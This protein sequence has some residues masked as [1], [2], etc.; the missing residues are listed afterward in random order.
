MWIISQSLYLTSPRSFHFEAKFVSILPNY[1]RAASCSSL[2]PSVYSW[3]FTLN[4]LVSLTR[5]F[6]ASSGE[7]I[8]CTFL[9]YFLA[10]IS[11]KDKLSSI[12]VDST[13]SSAFLAFSLFFCCSSNFACISF[14]FCSSFFEVCK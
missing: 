8:L 3:E 9:V 7:R 11:D 4:S 12:C 6:A 1:F 13:Y 10:M 14:F 5:I 2:E